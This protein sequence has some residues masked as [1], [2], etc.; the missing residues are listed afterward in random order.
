[1]VKV[2]L[3]D[4]LQTLRTKPVGGSRARLTDECD[5]GLVS[6][7]VMPNVSVRV[8]TFAGYNDDGDPTF[9]WET[10]VDAVRAVVF[11]DRTELDDTAGL[12]KVVATVTVPYDGDVVVT[13]SATVAISTGGDYR[14]TGVGQWPGWLKLTL[15]RVDHV[16]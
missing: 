14:V 2:R 8:R 11:E 7:V 10:V 9:T 1:M 12:V 3:K 16:D 13:E 6:V 5:E 4:D 15:E